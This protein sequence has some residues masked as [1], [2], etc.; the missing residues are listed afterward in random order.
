M[1]EN[2]LTPEQVAI[3]ARIAFIVADTSKFLEEDEIKYET[4]LSEMGL[5]SLDLITIQME[6]E[7][8]FHISIDD[9]S[10]NNFKTIGDI[11]LYVEKEIQ[12]KLV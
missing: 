7:K 6:T 11:V 2:V 5:D 1:A 4:Q 12:K 10:M 3:L 9:E 8:E